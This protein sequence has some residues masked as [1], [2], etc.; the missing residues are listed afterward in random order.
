MLP[1]LLQV[2][3]I[4][5]EKFG[6]FATLADLLPGLADLLPGLA[7]LLPSLADLLPS[8][9]FATEGNESRGCDRN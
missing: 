5:T 3:S 4:A 7:D 2:G 6:S 8:G 1:F 9:R